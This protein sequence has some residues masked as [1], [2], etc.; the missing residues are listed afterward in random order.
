MTK[1]M[2]KG[3]YSGSE[4]QATGSRPRVLKRVL[5]INPFSTLK[6]AKTRYPIITVEIRF[7]RRIA[8]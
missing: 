3:Q 7:G 2:I 8:L 5:L 6:K 4:Y 1:M